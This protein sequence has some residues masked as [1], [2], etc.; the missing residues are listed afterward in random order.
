M[1]AISRW[2]GI[3]VVF[4]NEAARRVTFTGNIKRY[5]TLNKIINMLEMTQQI[6]FRKEGDTIYISK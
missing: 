1:E 4:E 5:D 2:Y 6:K 3:E